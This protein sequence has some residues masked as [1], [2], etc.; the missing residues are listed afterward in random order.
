MNLGDEQGINGVAVI[1]ENSDDE[2]VDLHLECIKSA[3]ECG[4]GKYS[5]E[6]D[7]DFVAR[8]DDVGSPIDDLK[9]W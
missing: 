1:L 4:A 3:R 8:K 7:E 6:E 5:D 2:A 9:E